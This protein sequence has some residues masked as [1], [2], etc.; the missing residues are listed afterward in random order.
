MRHNGYDAHWL[1]R[2]E[3]ADWIPGVDPA[4]IPDDGAIF[5]P[6]EGWVDLAALVRQ[7]AA[8]LAAAGGRILSGVGAASLVVEGNRVTGPHSTRRTW[9]CA[10]PRTA[11]WSWTPTPRRPR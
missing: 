1:S 9:P 11:A 6:G 3:V 4:A 2:D 10:P 7:L 8:D 5:N